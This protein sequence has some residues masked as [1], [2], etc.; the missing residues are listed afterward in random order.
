MQHMT[1]QTAFYLRISEDRDLTELGVDRQRTACRALAARHGL[2]PDT[3]TEYVDD[4][5]SAW[6][7]KARPSFDRLLADLAAGRIGAV[8]A[9]APDR[10]ARNLGDYAAFTDAA[11]RSGARV[12]LVNGGEVGLD[13][14]STL[15][16]GVQALVSSWESGIKSVRVKAAAEQRALRG[17]PP[18][19]PRKFGYSLDHMSLVEPEAEAIREAAH[20]VLDGASLRSQV[21]RVNADP[22]LWTPSRKGRTSGVTERR[23]W[24]TTAFRTLLTRPALAGI[25]VYRGTEHRDVAAQWPTILT[26]A[27]HDDLTVLFAGRAT[28]PNDGAGR[29]AKHLLSGIAHCGAEGCDGTLGTTTQNR[30]GGKVLLYRCRYAGERQAAQKTPHVARVAS[31]VD[32]EVVAAVLARLSRG[33][34]QQAIADRS[35]EDTAGLLREREAVRDRMREVADAVVAGAFTPAQAATMNRGFMDRLAELDEKV[36]E[37]DQTGVLKL[38]GD[39][40][41]G[42]DPA[43]WWQSADIE[44]RRALV[45]ALVVVTV[46]P[47]RRGTRFNPEDIDIQ[48][49]V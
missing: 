38:V 36:A 37:A 42:V 28:G 21:K 49:R 33:D 22:E 30:P 7:G 31:K 19:G 25:V 44:T 20:A 40:G 3:V 15:S 47:T 26:V 23:P 24:Q 12:I 2:D 16:S 35:G 39:L 10:L 11:R 27:E 9:Y 46:L 18:G 29:P 4:N 8:L 34:L 45:D 1:Q 13:P 14:T 17:L 48:F 6:S 43:S 5:R 32:D 41:T